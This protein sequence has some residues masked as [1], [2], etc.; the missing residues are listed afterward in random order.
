MHEDYPA[1]L[2]RPKIKPEPDLKPFRG[3]TRERRGENANFVRESARK[4][5]ENARKPLKNKPE[6]DEIECDGALHLRNASDFAFL[7][8]DGIRLQPTSRQR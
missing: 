6:S 5:I 2:Y 8:P 4:A 3:K 1:K 7:L